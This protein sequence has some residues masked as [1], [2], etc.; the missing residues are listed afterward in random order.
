M[1][2]NPARIVHLDNKGSLRPG[3]DADVVVINPEEEYTIDVNRFVSKGK[4]S[5]FHGRKVKG[6]VKMTICGGLVVY[7]D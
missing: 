6:K 7:E 1:S 4:N 2:G 5:P 3:K